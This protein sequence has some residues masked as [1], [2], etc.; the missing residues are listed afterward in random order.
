[1]RQHLLRHWLAML[2]A[3]GV[4]NADAEG[5]WRMRPDARLADASACWDAFAQHASP[6]L[7]PAVLVEYFRDSA[8]CLDA[9]MDG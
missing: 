7:W 2:D 8:G 3:H 4:L 6:E 1:A 5:G 9:Q